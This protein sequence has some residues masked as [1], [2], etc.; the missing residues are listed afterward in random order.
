LGT[1]PYSIQVGTEENLVMLVFSKRERNNLYAFMQMK[2][3]KPAVL[4]TICDTEWLFNMW[5]SRNEHCRL[6]TCWSAVVTAQ[7]G[8]QP[9]HDEQFCDKQ[10]A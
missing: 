9:L 5:P 10:T 3:T 2:H 6:G 7:Q 4:A 1:L 8:S